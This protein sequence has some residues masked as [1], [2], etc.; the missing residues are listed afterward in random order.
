[1]PDQHGAWGN[2][3]FQ[4][5]ER[6]GSRMYEDPVSP[7]NIQ[8]MNVPSIML[9]V[10]LRKFI[11]AFRNARNVVGILEPRELDGVADQLP[12]IFKLTIGSV[13]KISPD[14]FQFHQAP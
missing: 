7:W 14:Q 11:A 10:S 3:P 4:L 8:H 12:T 5:R 6:I 2:A 13:R 9:M 1:M